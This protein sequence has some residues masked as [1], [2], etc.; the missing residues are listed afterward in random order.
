MFHSSQSV[1]GESSILETWVPKI[2]M[3]TNVENTEKLRWMSIYAHNHTLA[4]MRIM[5]GA[6]ANLGNTPGMGSVRLPGDP[7]SQTGFK[8]QARGSGDKPMSLLTLALQVANQTVGL[9]TI[10][11]VPMATPI[12][13][14][15]YADFVY[16][17]GKG[18]NNSNDL[19][20]SSVP[21]L[22]EVPV[23]LR[24][25][26]T[27][28]PDSIDLTP[29][30]P[31]TVIIRSAGSTNY[32]RTK[33]IAS[34]KINGH[35]IFAIEGI[36]NASNTLITTPDK[37]DPTAPTIYSIIDGVSTITFE[38]V[39]PTN[40]ATVLGSYQKTGGVVASYVNAL[41]NVIKGFTADA[42]QSWTRVIPYERGKG[43][44]TYSRS[45]A[46]KFYTKSV[47]AKT[48]QADIGITREQIHD[49]RQM[50]IDLMS[51]INAALTQELSQ[52][53]NANILDRIFALGAT[54]HVN[55]A[56][57][58]DTDFNVNLKASALTFAEIDQAFAQYN[59]QGQKGETIS[60]DGKLSY[61]DIPAIAATGGETLYTI[62][63]RIS[64]QLLA[65]KNMI[66]VRGN[67]GPADSIITNGNVVSVL[68]DVANFQAAPMIN[69]INQSS[70]HNAGTLANMQIYVDPFMKWGDTRV[71]CFRKGD[72]AT[73]G[74]VFMPYLMA[75]SVD[76]IA[77]GTMAP[78]IQIKSR[79]EIVEA[80][81]YPESYYL[82]LYVAGEGNLVR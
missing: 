51:Q 48:I 23:T 42:E 74:L 55:V 7:V 25:L 31:P 16:A 73:P 72:G 53:I 38:S 64:G 44:A 40:I 18:L 76:T 17:G 30:N 2:K 15:Q 75:E 12:G 60:F 67:R 29:A 37:D 33:Y 22:I 8:D 43:E 81:H 39:N 52:A 58:D 69:S 70:V 24:E 4:N 57:T 36:Y 54:N 47:A 6:Q 45:M 14:L 71:A 1:Y 35:A 41:E 50:N 82:T 32:I 34:S 65:A 77:E 20:V 78:K 68:Q 61:T 80:G 56:I 11:V 66:N 28:T 21:Y 26:K 13:F 59:N 5:E 63:R 27:A 9:D 49:S 62:N 19:N 3:M 79:Y 46:V 10:P